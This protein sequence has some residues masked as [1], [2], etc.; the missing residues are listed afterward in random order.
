MR[1]EYKTVP[2]LF[3]HLKDVLSSQRFLRMEGLN[4]DIPFFLCPFS[5][6]DKRNVE[7]MIPQLKKHL[8][9]NGIA[10]LELNLYDL[11]I[12]NLSLNNNLK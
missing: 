5:V 6:K 9:D 2:A 8:M 12:K 7:Q 11:C 3:Q 1:S 4:N 10:V